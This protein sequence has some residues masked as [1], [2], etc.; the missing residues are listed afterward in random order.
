MACC[1]RPAAAPFFSRLGGLLF[2]ATAAC[3]AA[4]RRAGNDSWPAPFSVRCPCVDTSNMSKAR[5]VHEDGACGKLLDFTGV[6]LG[7]QPHDFGS[8]QCKPVQPTPFARL[9]L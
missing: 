8:V 1:A 3:A 9:G 5:Y 7:C 2:L 6:G 4:P